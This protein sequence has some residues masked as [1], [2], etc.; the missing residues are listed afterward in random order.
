MPRCKLPPHCRTARLSS[1][2]RTLSLQ[3]RRSTA[4]VRRR[5][6]IDPLQRLLPRARCAC[7]HRKG[8]SRSSA[9]RRST[10]LNPNSGVTRNP[11]WDARK[12]AN[13]VGNATAS[14]EARSVV[15]N[16][17]CIEKR[18]LSCHTVISLI[19][20]V[21][22]SLLMQHCAVVLKHFVGNSSRRQHGHYLKRT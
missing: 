21:Q 5:A 3:C 15:E 10:T 13:H 2:K 12:S 6:Y 14:V 17:D 9:T 4:V 1:K 7:A 16:C 19:G 22:L 11:L 18:D 8:P 20:R